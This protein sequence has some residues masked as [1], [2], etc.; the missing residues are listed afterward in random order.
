MPR[1]KGETS[2]NKMIK[3]GNIAYP[4]KEI[5]QTKSTSEKIADILAKEPPKKR[6]KLPEHILPLEYPLFI[7]A[8]THGWVLCEAIKPIN[9]KPMWNSLAYT[10]GLQN[11][12]KLVVKYG[13][14]VPMDIQKL[15]DKI[16][17]IYTMIEAR[18]DNVDP[19]DLFIEYKTTEEFVDGFC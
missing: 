13:I 3:R 14:R 5:K 2:L 11:M 7:K 12:L 8:Y 10:T 19:K 1:P 17:S 4:V 18:I 16:D 9:D 15:S 6:H